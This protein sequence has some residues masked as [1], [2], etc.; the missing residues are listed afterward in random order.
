[1]EEN[2]LVGKSFGRWEVIKNCLTPTGRISITKYF[3]R[4]QCGNE[5]EV[6]KE[7]LLSGISKSCGCLRK[8]LVSNRCRIDLTNQKFNRL[9]ATSYAF[10]KNSNAYWDCICECGNTTQVEAPKL[11]SGSIKSC[12]CL[13]EEVD[14]MRFLTHGL[15]KHPLYNRWKA[16][17]QR[18]T[19]PTAVNYERYGGRGITVCNQWEDSFQ[20]FLDDMEST[21][22]KG[23]TLDR[24]D[25]DGPY[26]P[27]NCK[28]STLSEQSLNR[29]NT[30]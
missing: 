22:Q 25:N 18:C 4:C 1:M 20:A 6:R 2:T 28:W 15:S 16:V 10:T 21:F 12:G 26:S 7:K 23:L 14:Y 27:D 13:K 17:I 11:K 24:I 30:N 8:E 29:R 3:C 19:S 5:K 9:T